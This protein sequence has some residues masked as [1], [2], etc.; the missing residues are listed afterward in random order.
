MASVLSIYVTLSV[1]AKD[2]IKTG[3][4]SHLMPLSIHH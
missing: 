4:E 2:K 3:T 1:M